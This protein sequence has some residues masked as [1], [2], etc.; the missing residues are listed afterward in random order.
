MN[1]EDVQKTTPCEC[2]CPLK[3]SGLNACKRRPGLLVTPVVFTLCATQQRKFDQ[4]DAD[5]RFDGPQ[6]TEVQASLPAMAGRFVKAHAKNIGK[7]PASPELVADRLSIC[8]ACNFYL[9]DRKRCAHPDCG[10]R[11][12][13]KARMVDEH[14]PIGR[15]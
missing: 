1:C 13:S 2:D 5:Q 12:Q 7:A 15:W 14:C 8:A 10:C 6:A 4:L 3:G 11:L 9:A